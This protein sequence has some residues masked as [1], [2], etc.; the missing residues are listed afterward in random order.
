MNITQRIPLICTIAVAAVSFLA[1]AAKANLVV[2]GGFEDN[3]T[4]VVPGALG[5]APGGGDTSWIT[6]DLN[7]WDVGPSTNSP[8]VVASNQN[9][10]FG[11]ISNGDAAGGGPHSGDLAAVFP[12]FPVYDGYISQAVTGVVHDY[13]YKIS[14]WLANQIGDN[15]NNH[16]SVKW[17]GT[18][19]TAGD[20]LTGGR[21]LSGGIPHIP[22]AIPVPTGWTYYEFTTNAD[23]DNSRLTFIGGN[24]A[25]G[26][27][28][29]DV[30][31]D[32]VAVPET[33]SFGMIAGLGLLAIGSTMRIRR[34]AAVLA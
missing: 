21:D 7:G 2:N 27:L 13:I 9:I 31:V 4:T 6:G 14:F 8:N 22:G 24:D 29:D 34:K 17:G 10:Y 28:I 19:A 26:I 20:P 5:T 23:V 25:A 18:I 11:T 15:A 12:N 1:P 30:S 3:P 16:I 32:F 33:S